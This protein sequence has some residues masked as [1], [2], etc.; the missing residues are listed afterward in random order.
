MILR[1]CCLDL[2]PLLLLA[3]PACAVVIPLLLKDGT[4][5]ALRKSP[6]HP[7]MSAAGAS[8]STNVFFEVSI[9]G[10]AAGRIVF[11]LFDDVTP[12]TARNF[13]LLCTKEKGFGFEGSG[14]HRVI[15][16]FMLQGGD[17]TNHNGTGGKSIYGEKFPDEN[18]K[19]KHDT[20]GLLSM[21]NAGPNTNGSQARLRY[22]AAAS[23]AALPLTAFA[24]LH[25]HCRD[26]SPERQARCVWQSCRG[27]GHR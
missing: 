21:A 6:L 2:S 9:G 5:V 11:K 19:L 8:P 23:T 3:P 16:K 18:F 1:T 15:P 27:N 13:R 7:A 25:H 20:P 24:V 22:A 4:C 10:K 17:F 12:K 26:A 14:F